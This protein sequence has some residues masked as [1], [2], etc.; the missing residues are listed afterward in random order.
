MWKE[1]IRSLNDLSD[2][3]ESLLAIEGRK[4]AVLVAVDLKGLEALVGEEEQQLERIRAA[5]TSRRDALLA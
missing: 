5:E 2:A 1:L 4:R 3:Y